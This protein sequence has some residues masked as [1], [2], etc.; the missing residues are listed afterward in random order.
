MKRLNVKK[1][2]AIGA[3]AALV[4]AALAP[5]VSAQSGV[6]KGDLISDTGSPLVDV[7]VGASAANSD[8]VWA[9]NIA[10][11]IAQLATVSTTTDVDGDGSI[12]ITVGGT[13]TYGGSAKTYD[14]STYTLKTDTG[15]ANEF[16]DLKLGA[17]QL[18][19]LSN[20]TESYTFDGTSYEQTV[21]ERI[22]INADARFLHSSTKVQD[23]VVQMKNTGDFNYEV[24]FS[25]GLPVSDGLN[26]PKT[27]K[28]KDD[29]NDSIT[30]PFLG[31]D[32]SLFRAQDTGGVKEIRLLKSTDAKKRYFSGDSL[33]GLKGTGAHEGENLSLTIDN[34]VQSTSQSSFE[35]EISLWDE[36]GNLL[37][38]ETA[39]EGQFLETILEGSDGKTA[40]DTSLFTE[41][42][43]QDIETSQGYVTMTRGDDLIILRDGQEFPY[44]STSTG[45]S[46]HNWVVNLTSGTSSTPDVNAFTKITIKNQNTKWNVNNPLWAGNDALTESGMEGSN[47]AV[48]LQDY[49]EDTIGYGYA[50]VVFDGFKNDQD[51]TKFQLGNGNMVYFDSTDEVE[52]TVPFVI[53]LDHS[54][55]PNDESSFTLLNQTFYYRTNSTDVNVLLTQNAKLNGFAIDLNAGAVS[56]GIGFHDQSTSSATDLNAGTARPV[57]IDINQVQYR[58]PHC[59]STGAVGG[60]TVQM[61]ADGNFQIAKVA[62]DTVADADYIGTDNNFNT[63]YYED[64]NGVNSTYNGALLALSGTGMDSESYKYAYYSNE[65]ESVLWLLL[66]KATTWTGQY[67]YT[68]T[69]IGTDTVEDGTIDLNWFHPDD[70]RL[71]GDEADNTK[72]VAKFQLDD[73]GGGTAGTEIY[74]H[75][76]LEDDADIISLPDNELSRYTVDANYDGGTKAAIWSMSYRTDSDSFFDQAWTDFGTKYSVADGE[77]FQ[78]WI[79]DNR[80]NLSLTVRGTDST[81]TTT[82]GQD[83]TGV[84][85]G[86]TVT[87]DTGTT[88]TV[89][90]V[91]GTSS[92]QTVVPAGDLVVLDSGVSA[93]GNHVIVGGYI[94][95]SLAQGLVLGDG[96]TLE[97]S[98]TSSSS[99]Y[100]LE[101]LSNGDFVV[102]GYTAAQT[103]LAAQ[104]FIDEL[105]ALLA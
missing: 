3:G 24:T 78:A 74:L 21:K 46:N 75:A 26:K 98:L 82:G 81:E 60:T 49:S 88:V 33:T 39:G 47:E 34:I 8:V 100:V 35:V 29:G 13:T 99:D 1:L 4:G 53:A 28:F 37:D 71:G 18:D 40:L 62:F 55:D 65:S 66:D 32:Y 2:V 10:S 105:E 51:L 17:S 70:L 43:R 20:G 58:L 103:G 44:D 104:E 85:S 23:L 12:D 72:F 54:G 80:L 91:G 7:V 5:I 83:F 30:F 50:S 41:K 57:A 9:S 79:P 93:G 95:N 92:G 6:V 36:E 22:W 27:N 76:L 101:K 90:T 56:C 45:T 97:E 42:I 69:F 61:V 102:A 38:S 64:K 94:V 86:S 84:T 73:N 63:W 89:G 25:K 59:T 31:V 77:T 68:P 67:T 19:F 16:A 48:L 11:R 96:T 87:T 14:S 52:R 15:E